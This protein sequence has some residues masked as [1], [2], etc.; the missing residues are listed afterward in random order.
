MNNLRQ[1]LIKLTK[2]KYKEKTLKAAQE[3]N[4][5]QGNPDKGIGS[6]FSRNSAGQKG[7]T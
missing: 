3:S 7:F 4:N 1:I 6:F 2:I 5:I